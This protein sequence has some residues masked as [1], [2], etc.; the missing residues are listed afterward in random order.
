MPREFNYRA[1]KKVPGP[2]DAVVL[3][4]V[5]NCANLRKRYEDR[6]VVMLA[7]READ[8]LFGCSA[9][10]DYEASTDYK[11]AREIA[12]DHLGASSRQECD[13]IIAKLRVR[14]ARLLE[15]N[16]GSLI[17]IASA[18]DERGMLTAREVRAL[19]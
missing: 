12:K 11:M 18:L 15:K 8:Q 7:G 14:A 1:F 10:F 19:Y 2:N 3:R 4:T 9:G 13:D 17:L 6:I 5:A 16:Y